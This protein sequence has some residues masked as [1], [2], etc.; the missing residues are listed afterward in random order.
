MQQSNKMKTHH[1]RR[2]ALK[3]AL[4]VASRLV[5]AAAPL[6][7]A[8]PAY[9]QQQAPL[10]TAQEFESLTQGG[11]YNPDQVRPF[12]SRRAAQSA[13]DNLGD[14]NDDWQPAGSH[15]F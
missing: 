4:A 10:A 13:S 7:A 3:L 12:E 6:N 9:V 5:L 2:V 15:S 8:E 1:R 11:P 14:R